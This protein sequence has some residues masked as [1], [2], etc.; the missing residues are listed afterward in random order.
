MWSEQWGT[1]IWGTLAVPGLGPMG[2][3]FLVGAMLG[4]FG[5]RRRGLMN[6]ST[7]LLVFGVVSVPI[8]VYAITLPHTF[9]NGTVADADEVNA[10][11]SALSSK[12]GQEIFRGYLT[13]A[14]STSIVT[15]DGG[16]ADFDT[17][18]NSDPSVIEVVPGG[19]QF[20]QA[21]TIMW[22]YHQDFIVA[23]STGYVSVRVTP[24]GQP[25][26]A[27]LASASGG[28]WDGLSNGGV[29]QVAVGDTLLV[30]VVGS[31]V[32]I[33]QF[34]GGNAAWSSLTILWMP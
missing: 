30:N 22:Q 9:T 10:N 4:A 27:T 3:M 31:G 12:V 26:V 24:L 6:F 13:S 5:L 18:V 11:F 19:V 34:E 21:G 16:L 7:A 15:N 14:A 2:L 33:T 1:M 8:A 25:E 23:G 32:D 29:A 28:L 17:Q 20:N